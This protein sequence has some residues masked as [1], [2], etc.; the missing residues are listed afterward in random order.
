[1]SNTRPLRLSVLDQSPVPDGFTPSDALNNSLSLAQHVDKLGYTRLWYS[2]HHSMNLLACTAPEILIGRAAAATNHIRVG[3]GGIMLPHYAPLKVA[4]VFR[5]LHA[6]F[7]NRIDLGLGRAPGG[8][9]LEAYALRRD[10]KAAQRDD[11]P[12]QLAELTAFLHPERFPAD[13][14]FRKIHV[15]PSAPGAPVMWLLGS[16]TWSSVTA[17]REGLPYA[18]AHFF[19]PIATRQ[20]I[21][22]YQQ[23]FTPSPEQ[24]SPEATLAIGVICAPT[25]EEA[26]YLYSSVRLLQ[27]RIRMDDRRPVATPD[28]ALR[29]LSAVPTAPNPLVSFTAGSYD[30]PEEGEW[31]RYVVGTP[32]KVAVQLRSIA[33]ALNL[34][35]LI[36]NTI[37]H[38]HEA[39]LRSY[40]L[41][42]EV[43]ELVSV[44]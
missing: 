14:P 40:S 27:R 44:A 23:N 4:E 6:M 3:S 10:R 22:Y 35:E 15:M 11:F 34:K 16:S 21:E 30:A 29:E 8:G 42:A 9:Q 43:M 36:V 37:T 20:A 41:L 13:H 5:T 17:A 7:P 33:T 38:S 18:F 25:Q 24:K 39:R 1:M 32:E 12:D 19:S 31:P 26:E 28:E 2:E